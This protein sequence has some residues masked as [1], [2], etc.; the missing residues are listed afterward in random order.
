LI[1]D[2]HVRLAFIHGAF[3]SDPHS[4]LRGEPQY[5]KY[6]RIDCFETAPWED[7]G[8]LIRESSCFDPR[9]AGVASPPE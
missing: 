8:E 4:L 5:K 3:L 1:L 6:A 9:Q 7:L 2:D